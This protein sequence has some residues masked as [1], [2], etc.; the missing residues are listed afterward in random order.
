MPTLLQLHPIANQLA[1]QAV[2]RPRRGAADE[3][4]FVRGDEAV[5][6]FNLGAAASLICAR[7]PSETTNARSGSTRSDSPRGFG[8]C[9]R[10]VR[11]GIA[12]SNEGA[13]EPSQE[14]RDSTRPDARRFPET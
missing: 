5:V 7:R 11:L 14:N 9:V 4:P 8:G 13:G 1:D 12:E 10:R 6:V 3:E 2:E